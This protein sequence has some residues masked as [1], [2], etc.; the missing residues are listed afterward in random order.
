VVGYSRE[1]KGEGTWEIVL[2]TDRPIA[3]SEAQSQVNRSLRFNISIITLQLTKDDSGNWRGDGQMIVGAEL[4]V[5]KEKNKLEIK[6]YASRP[7]VLQS[8]A[9]RN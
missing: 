2:V 4:N 9:L 5:N 1:F 8:I 7:I 6:N 3:F